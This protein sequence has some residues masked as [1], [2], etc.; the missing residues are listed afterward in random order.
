LAHLLE[1]RD[2]QTHFDTRWGVLKA[3]DGVSFDLDAGETLGVVGESG[4]GKSMTALSIA[5]LVPAPA[6][7]IAGGSIR[8]NGEELV[9]KSQEDLRAIRGTELA[10]VLQ[11]PMASL[12]PMFRIGDQVGEGLRVHRGM[13]GAALR[14][15]V[16]GLLRAMRIPSPEERVRAWPH[17]L[18]GGMRQRVVGAIGVACEPRLLIADEPTSALD[19][20]IQ[21]QYLTLLQELQARTG[22]AIIFITHD[23]GVVA[24]LCHRA[25]VM[26][27]GRIVELAQVDDMFA[28]PRHPYTLGL[29]ASIPD[30]TKPAGRR[31]AIPGQPPE[32][33]RLPP[34]CPFAPRC[35]RV[36]PRCE[37]E[38][39]PHAES[40]GRHAVACWRPD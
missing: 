31:A 9:G 3:V 12:D 29:L 27:A 4:S 30:A 36:A 5:G 24:R 23:F 33:H 1:I 13:R 26:Y 39:P 22:L 25:A 6:G 38:R 21:L 10:M 8:F 40:A 19:A 34:G 35:A 28:R 15:K 18:S 17:Q 20:T 11:D 16:V 7:R 14:E 37:A 32:L 2:L